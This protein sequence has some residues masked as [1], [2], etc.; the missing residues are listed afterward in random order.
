[1]LKRFFHDQA[2]VMLA[3]YALLLAIICAGLACGAYFLGDAISHAMAHAGELIAAEWEG[4]SSDKS[5]Q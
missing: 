1:M 2:G 4:I 3:E 5:I